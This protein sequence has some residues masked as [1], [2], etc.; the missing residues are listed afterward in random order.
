MH[1]CRIGIATGF[2]LVCILYLPLAAQVPCC[3]MLYLPVKIYLLTFYTLLKAFAKLCGHFGASVQQVQQQLLAHKPAAALVS[4][5]QN[6]Q[7]RFLRHFGAIWA[8]LRRPGPKL[9]TPRI[10]KLLPIGWVGRPMTRSNHDP[11]RSS[12]FGPP[13]LSNPLFASFR[14]NLGHFEA[15]RAKIGDT[16]NPEI[17]SN[18]LGGTPHD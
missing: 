15:T 11:R 17:A 12:R 8:I 1:V 10:P 2:H 16:P 4:A 5:Q 9:G 14:S 3:S 6:C 13:E 7:T 18:R